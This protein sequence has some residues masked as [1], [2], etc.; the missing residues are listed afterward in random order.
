MSFG[1]RHS[2]AA[3][4]RPESRLTL[5]LCLPRLNYA[6]AFI[7]LGIIKSKLPIAKVETQEERLQDLVGKWVSFSSETGPI[8][9]GILEYCEVGKRYKLQIYKR[10]VPAPDSM[11]EER[12]RKYSP[13]KSDAMWLWIEQKNYSQIHPTGKKFNTAK[14]VSKTQVKKIKSETA[15]IS[16]LSELFGCD[17]SAPL[18]SDSELL[19]SIH[20]NK[21]RVHEEIS[22]SLYEWKETRL[23]EVIK[24][25][26]RA[27]EMGIFHCDVT[28]IKEEMPA[29]EK[30]IVIIEADRHLPD[31][32]VASRK[33][34]R[35]IILG[36]NAASYDEGAASLMQE[37][38]IRCGDCDQFHNEVSAIKFLSFF[39]K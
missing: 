31:R 13:P 26:Q 15:S 16:N 18:I 6:A 19:F 22:N 9:V 10:K 25:K 3:V 5:A 24:P 17:L 12:W 39:Q 30:T 21:Q 14:R 34:N 35:I 28:S 27:P 23:E 36:R 2:R 4:E 7:G 32:L 1:E 8:K 38:D 29:N 11:S 33:F 37:F 20:G